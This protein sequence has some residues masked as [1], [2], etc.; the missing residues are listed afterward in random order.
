VIT[1]AGAGFDPAARVACPSWA[2]TTYVSAVQLTAIVPAI[3]GAPGTSVAVAV[4]VANPDGGISAV[5]TFM[6]VIGTDRLQTWTTIDAV[7]GE[8]PQFLRGQS[9]KDSTI[10]TWMRSVA[11]AIEAA[12]V[13]R[14]LPLDA[15]QWQQPGLNAGPDPASVLEMINRL[16][17]AARL[18]SAIAGNFGSGDWALRANLQKQYDAEIARLDAGQYDKFFRPGAA[19]VES[20]PLLAAGDMTDDFGNVER[21]FTKGKVF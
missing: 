2:E 4:L 15:S 19:T 6:V 16:G 8:V 3:D 20:G 11:Q 18:A 10:Q 14:G 13:R 7:C 5:R 21:S 9:I 1:L 17:A 12:M